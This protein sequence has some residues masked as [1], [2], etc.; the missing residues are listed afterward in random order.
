MVPVQGKWFYPKKTVPC[1]PPHSQTCHQAKHCCASPND[2]APSRE[3]TVCLWYCLPSGTACPYPP[4]HCGIGQTVQTYR[5]SSGSRQ[6]N[7]RSS[8]SD[9][10]C[11]YSS[12]LAHYYYSSASS[13]AMR[14]VP[15]ATRPHRLRT[16]PPDTPDLRRCIHMLPPAPRLGWALRA[17]RYIPTPHSMYIHCYWAIEPTLSSHSLRSFPSQ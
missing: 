5:Y 13:A 17:E 12:L 6:W 1:S 16:H 11:L 4:S 15:S 2:Q 9:P 3:S 8:S 10:T 14:S 7:I